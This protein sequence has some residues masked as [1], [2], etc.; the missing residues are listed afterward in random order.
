VRGRDGYDMDGN[1]LRVEL[2]RGGRGEPGGR[3]GGRGGES[4][5]C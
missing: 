3:M 5:Y 4:P 1:R 2:A